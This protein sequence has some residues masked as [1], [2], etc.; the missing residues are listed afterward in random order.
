MRRGPP[1]SQVLRRGR[2]EAFEGRN[3]RC[4]WRLDE[5]A[6]VDIGR[7]VALRDMAGG[8]LNPRGD[9]GGADLLCEEATGP[10]ATSTREGDRALKVPPDWDSP[11]FLCGVRARHG[12][13]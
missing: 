12:R 8:D 2:G 9:P 4:H 10:E 5:G 7:E 6:R 13:E 3:L 1:G 11:I